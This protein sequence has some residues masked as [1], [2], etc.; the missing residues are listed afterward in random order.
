MYKNDQVII[1]C[2]LKW[3][4]LKWE[5]KYLCIS[6]LVTLSLEVAV[7]LGHLCTKVFG[8]VYITIATDSQVNEA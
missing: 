3:T 2:T 5:G 6:W 4:G 1:T 8:A 7:G